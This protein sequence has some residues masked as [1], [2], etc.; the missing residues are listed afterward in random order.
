MK[1]NQGFITGSLAFFMAAG[2]TWAA[3]APRMKM[4]TEV[5]PGIATPDKL[6][7]S[8]GALMASL[9]ERIQSQ[10]CNPT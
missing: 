7:T 8:L 9:T 1:A 10:G 4:T 5:P 2:T 3:E 6:E